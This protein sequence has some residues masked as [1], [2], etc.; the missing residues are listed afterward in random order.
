MQKLTN[1]LWFDN[2]GEEA[3]KFYTS[4]FKNSKILATTRYGKEGFEIH[5]RPEGSVMTVTFEINGQEFMAL[6]GG[7]HFKFTEAISFVINCRTQ[8][9][10]DQ[11]TEKL[12]AHKQS[13]QCG[14]VK[15]KFGLSWQIVPTIMN[16][17]MQDKDSQKRERVM[18]AM[19][20]MKRLNIAALKKAYEG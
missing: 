8:E 16:E 2:Q 18:K 19:L 20:Q 10:M 11:F 1:C 12:S 6:N 5:G 17:M 3:A 9:E 13:E 15:D 7:P 14:W 4:V